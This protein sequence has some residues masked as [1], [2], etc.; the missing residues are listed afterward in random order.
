MTSCSLGSLKSVFKRYR[1]LFSD[2]KKAPDPDGFS[3]GSF[4]GVWPVV[5]EA[6][7]DVVLHFF[8]TYYLP[9]ICAKCMMTLKD[10]KW[11]KLEASFNRLYLNV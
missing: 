7:C 2:S 4:K 1:L 10:L 11:T 6:F 5:G 3:V 8:K 9:L